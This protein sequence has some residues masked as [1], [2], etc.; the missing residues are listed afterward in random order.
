MRERQTFPARI[1]M[2]VLLAGLFVA[3]P[4]VSRATIL[5]F[6]IPGLIDW[7]EIPGTYGDN[8]RSIYDGLGHYEQGA[9]WTP[10]ITVEYRTFNLSDNSTRTNKLDYWSTGFG[11]L[12]D[13]A[14]STSQSFMGEI[15]LVPEAGWSV[16][17]DG[18]GLGGYGDQLDQIVRIVD[19]NYQILVDYSPVDVG[20]AGHN[21][22]TPGLTHAGTVRIQFGPNWN[23]GIDNVHFHQVPEPATLAL[24]AIGL[25]V[26][27]RRRRRPER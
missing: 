18:F 7:Q 14:Q 4:A 17:L 6:E 11:D 13:V 2:I 3:W 9:G 26:A 25:A 5:T 22:F 20:G 19:E 24:V 16:V 23:T 12:E 15:S 1:G 10:N 27:R 8:V 21:T